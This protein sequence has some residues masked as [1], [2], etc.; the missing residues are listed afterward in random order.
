MTIEDTFMGPLGSRTSPQPGTEYSF[1]IIRY[2]P[3]EEGALYKGFP[4]YAKYKKTTPPSAARFDGTSWG[5]STNR[6]I[7]RIGTEEY[8]IPF[9][10]EGYR[11]Y[12]AGSELTQQVRIRATGSSAIDFAKRT[13]LQSSQKFSLG[14]RYFFGNKMYVATGKTAPYNAL[15][16]INAFDEL[17][18]VSR[19][20]GNPYTYDGIQ[21]WVLDPKE[22]GSS[23]TE[24]GKL[25]IPFFWFNPMDKVFYPVRSNLSIVFDPR[26]KSITEAGQSF[27]KSISELTGGLEKGISFAEDF[28]ALYSPIV[29]DSWRQTISQAILKY[30]IDKGISVEAAIALAD[31]LSFG[32]GGKVGAGQG[33]KG[34]KAVNNGLPNNGS[35]GQGFRTRRTVSVRNNFSGNGGYVSPAAR[36][37]SSA[38][39]MVQQYRLPPDNTPVTLRHIFRFAP[40]QINY[41]SLGSNWIDI[42]RSGNTPLVDWAG[43]KLMQVS[44]SFLVA[45]DDDANFDS[46]VSPEN[47]INIGIDEKLLELRQMATAPYPV[48]LL[49]FDEMLKNQMRF[50]FD[51][52]KGVEFVITDFS[53]SSTYRTVAGEINRAQCEITL[54]EIPIETIDLVD[55]PP[56]IFPNIQP[57]PK[58]KETKPPTRPLA[59]DTSDRQKAL[60]AEAAEAAAKEAAADKLA[61]Q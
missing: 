14:S 57:A 46:P 13:P 29:S 32:I 30:Y 16:K 23:Y 38:P 51:G 18:G 17:K 55:F 26:F 10:D 50:P 25:V 19:D 8:W 33:T 24:G 47:R 42:E 15:L 59:T 28:S 37:S 6:A 4:I 5:I 44:F 52:G 1:S 54:R 58:D 12:K 21:L 2:L 3:N 27:I 7:D 43:Y 20:T 9:A 31:G 60:A 45:G 11:I 53:I 56:L 34:G 48:T 41:A 22:S 39:Q 35:S 40:N 61:N 49:G 36:D